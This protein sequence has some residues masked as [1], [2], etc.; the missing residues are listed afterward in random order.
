MWFYF[1]FSAPLI[2][3]SLTLNTFASIPKIEVLI[4]KS[5]PKIIVKGENITKTY[6]SLE[7]SK[8]LNIETSP[9]KTKKTYPGKNTIVLNCNQSIKDKWAKLL[10]NHISD[11]KSLV[12]HESAQCLD[13]GKDNRKIIHMI[14]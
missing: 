11:Y 1:V 2:L 4:G 6:T 10:L 5:I 9:L 8:S 12:I 13:C 14:N 7:T 3:F